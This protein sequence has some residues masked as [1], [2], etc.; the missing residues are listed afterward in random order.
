MDSGESPRPRERRLVA[1]GT[2]TG[3]LGA[4]AGLL[5]LAL[6]A[7]TR[8]WLQSAD[9]EWIEWRVAVAGL[10]VLL[11]LGA[12]L[13]MGAIAATR[14]SQ[15]RAVETEREFYAGHVPPPPQQWGA[16]A[17]TLGALLFVLGL[18]VAVYLGHLR[19]GSALAMALLG[20]LTLLFA[21]LFL[22]A[23]ERGEP[24][25]FESHW[26]GLGGGLGGWRISPALAYLVATLLFGALVAGL[27]FQQI[28]G[29]SEVATTQEQQR[30]EG[31]STPAEGME[32][33]G[34]A[35]EEEPTSNPEE[36]E[37]PAT[38]DD[39]MGATEPPVEAEG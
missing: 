35:D 7:Q 21:L 4:A 29:E 5:A 13:A 36:P 30:E 24:P 2:V 39:G 14:L 10:V 6:S 9:G 1:L 12:V 31:P 38:P 20:T 23:V 3:F 34:D 37:A 8:G 28:P 25:L 11:F 22:R 26:G 15:L 16:G 17:W 33:D 32:D 18:V 19:V 27:T